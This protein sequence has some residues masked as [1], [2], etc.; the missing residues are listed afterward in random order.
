MGG[1]EIRDT[2]S[3]V[4]AR[5]PS[6]RCVGAGQCRGRQTGLEVTLQSGRDVVTDHGEGRMRVQVDGG[7]NGIG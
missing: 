7:A 3:S 2:Q 1:F 5:D 6:G 4:G